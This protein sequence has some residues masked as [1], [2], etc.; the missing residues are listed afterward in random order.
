MSRG[1]RRDGPIH[2]SDTQQSERQ[3]VEKARGEKGVEAATVD[4]DR[5]FPGDKGDPA[6]G[7]IR[8]IKRLWRFPASLRKDRDAE[9]VWPWHPFGRST[10]PAE[11]QAIVIHFECK[12]PDW[13]LNEQANK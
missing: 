9:G 8:E 6:H 2:E 1:Q 13:S 3:V 12:R 11:A 5:V 4:S 10:E 7:N